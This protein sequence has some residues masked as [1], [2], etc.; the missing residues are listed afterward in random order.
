MGVCDFDPIF[1]LLS[2]KSRLHRESGELVAEPIPPQ[3]YRRWRPS[4]QALD[5][6]ARLN[7]IDGAHKKFLSDFLLQVVSFTVDSNPLL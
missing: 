3:Q 1:E 6:G 4:S 2:L 5:G 7:G